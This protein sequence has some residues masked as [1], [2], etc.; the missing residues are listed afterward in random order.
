[1]GFQARMGFRDLMAFVFQTQDI[2]AN[3]NILFY[4][5]HAHE[6]RERLRN[7]FPFILGA[8]NLEILTTTSIS[9]TGSA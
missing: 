2:V 9:M 3:Q 1:M 4:K 7:W 8:E 6:H 5:T